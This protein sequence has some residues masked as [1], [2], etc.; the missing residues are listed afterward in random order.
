MTV[1]KLGR[2]EK[3]WALALQDTGGTLMN[4]M[5]NGCTCSGEGSSGAW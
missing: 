2:E 3:V 4:T 1:I 5:I